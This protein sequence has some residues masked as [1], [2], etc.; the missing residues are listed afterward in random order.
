MAMFLG[1]LLGTVAGP[2]LGMIPDI[3]GSGVS[4]PYRG[5]GTGD[6]FGPLLGLGTGLLGGGGGGGSSG[7][8][9]ST[10]PMT[11]TTPPAPTYLTPSY[12]PSTG[13]ASGAHYV[14]GG[15]TST[16]MADLMN[17]PAAWAGGAVLLLLVLRK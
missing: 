1:G 10:T 6:P 14:S 3:P 5:T 9:G 12:N 15:G 13:S 7:G 8:G 17:S 2:L 11:P 4:N 16:V